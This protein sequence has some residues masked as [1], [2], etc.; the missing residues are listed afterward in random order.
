MRIKIF[1]T[2][3]YISYLFCAVVCIMLLFDRTGLIIPTFFAVLVHEG[4]HLVAMW[5]AEC[6]PRAVRLIPTSVQIVRDFSCK[7]G[8]EIAIAICG[9]V[10]NLILFLILILNYAAFKGEQSLRF[11]VLNLVMAA[12]N[13]LPVAGL[14]G[15]TILCEIIARF[16]DIYKAERM[17]RIITVIFAILIFLLGIYLWVSGKLN[18]SV[19]IVSLYLIVCVLIK[20]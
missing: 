16:T 19:F 4:G 17:V 7:R 14:D 13:L 11:A 2:E 3:I 12:F 18:I 9:P 8:A 1:E 5:A 10:A 6:Q 20:K 15:G